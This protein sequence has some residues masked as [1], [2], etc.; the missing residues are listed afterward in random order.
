MAT[1]FQPIWRC[2]L[3]G[4]GGLLGDS[5]RHC[6]NCGHGR[7]DE[8]VRFPLWEELVAPA[9]HRFHGTDRFCCEQG[10]S[11]HAR[12]CGHCGTSLTVSPR[13]RELPRA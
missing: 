11:A 3:C 10:W 6:A 8:P 9:D 2:R 4:S 13:A 1:R 5:H 12:H 7:D